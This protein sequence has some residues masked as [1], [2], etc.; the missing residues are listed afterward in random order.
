MLRINPI[1]I[2]QEYEK[3]GITVKG[4]QVYKK[5]KLLS[6]E[7]TKK[8]ENEALKVLTDKHD[9]YRPKRNVLN[10]AKDLPV[11]CFNG[12]FYRDNLPMTDLEIYELIQE[13][14]EHMD[15]STIKQVREAA[16][17]FKAVD[18]IPEYQLPNVQPK[19]AMYNGKPFRFPKSA[20]HLM[21]YYL[22]E[23]KKAYIFFIMSE[24]G[25]GKSTFTNF[26]KHLF[27]KET[28]AADTKFMNQFTTSFIAA[29]RLTIF[30]DCTTKYIENSHLLKQ[31]SGE[32]EVQIEA[33]GMQA[34]SGKIDS[35]LL[36]VGNQPIGYD[37]LDTGMQRR[38]IN[39]PWTN[40]F[41]YDDPKWVT[42]KWTWEEIAEQIE[43][44]KTIG[45]MDYKALNEATI[46]ETIKTKSA[47][48]YPIQ[49]YDMYKECE[50]KTY[51]YENFRTYRKMVTKYF[52]QEEWQELV[53]ARDKEEF[54]DYEFK[55]S[56]NSVRRESRKFA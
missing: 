49:H 30:S 38:F 7:E 33:K 36:F 3:D 42:Y 11:T 39:L 50:S 22:F 54:I 27:D 51:N 10:A 52:S 12:T 35:Y 8:L 32:D 4:K 53:A 20:Y 29:S 40:E 41:Q 46:K 37:I 31:I 21:Y 17:V 47:F 19:A 1:L 26:L 34:Y 2:A 55:D 28:Y 24:G 43:H 13:M 5:G 45:P 18:N 48:Y 23:P 44:C 56:E 14:N 25:K 9:Y 6:F 16:T 15:W